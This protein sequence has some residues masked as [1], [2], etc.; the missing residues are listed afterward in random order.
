MRQLIN[1]IFSNQNILLTQRFLIEC[2]VTSFYV[3]FTFNSLNALFDA[4]LIEQSYDNT[5]YILPQHLQ[6]AK[7]I[8][9][10]FDSLWKILYGSVIYG[11]IGL[12]W[13]VSI[14]LIRYLYKKDLKDKDK[15]NS[16]DTTP[17]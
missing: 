9:I 12:T 15:S 13:P 5:T 4:N 7:P 8:I 14:P 3:G 17:Y 11:L 1:N 16:T 6:L 2:G 10:M